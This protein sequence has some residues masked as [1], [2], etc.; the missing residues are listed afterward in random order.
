MESLP[1]VFMLLILLLEIQRIVRGKARI[2]FVIINIVKYV[3]II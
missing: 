1:S 2:N 3:K